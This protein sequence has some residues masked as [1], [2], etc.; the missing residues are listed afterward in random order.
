MEEHIKPFTDT[1]MAID[2]IA[3]RKHHC[4]ILIDQNWYIEMHNRYSKL[5]SKH[6]LKLLGPKYAMIDPTFSKLRKSKVLF[7]EKVEKNLLFI[8]GSDPFNITN[9][10]AKLL[11]DSYFRKVNVDIVVGQYFKHL[12]SLK[13]I[14]SKRT[15]F[16]LYV[17]TS[18]ISKIMLKADMAI[19]ATGVNTWERMCLKIPSLSI[20]FS[21]NQSILA[22]DLASEKIIDH[23]GKHSTLEDN[24]IFKRI[25]NKIKQI[26]S[27]FENKIYNNMVDGNGVERITDQILKF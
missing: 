25:K 4:D 17:Q 24:S 20:A 15:K 2:D 13:R 12:R 14:V 18:N 11:S 5:I 23:L 27:G 26:E 7:T 9:R 1:I 8:G 6:C 10:F 22:K 21:E 19:G 3:N 16:K